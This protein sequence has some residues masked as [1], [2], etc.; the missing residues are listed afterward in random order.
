MSQGRL[1]N[2]RNLPEAMLRVL[3][4]NVGHVAFS[5]TEQQK[6]TAVYASIFLSNQGHVLIHI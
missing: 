2:S 6:P 5:N 4:S 3:L 1:L